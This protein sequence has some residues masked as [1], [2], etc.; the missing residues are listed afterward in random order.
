MVPC[1]QVCSDRGCLHWNEELQDCEKFPDGCD[2]AVEHLVSDRENQFLDGEQHGLWRKESDGRWI[3]EAIYVRGKREGKGM[4]WHWNGQLGLEV[5]YKGG[6][7]N[8]VWRH[9][10]EEGILVAEGSYNKNGND[11]GMFRKW[12]SNGTLVIEENYVDG[13]LHG[14]RR[15]WH[16][17][18]QLKEEGYYENGQENGEMRFWNLDG[19]LRFVMNY[20]GGVLLG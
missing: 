11:D 7:L 19:S 14:L 3:R 16:E 13:M 20:K 4:K 15:E 1:Y 17:N 2:Y 10:N 5:T 9:W 8:G 6:I 12:S 18:G